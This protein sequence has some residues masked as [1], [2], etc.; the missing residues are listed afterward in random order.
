MNHPFNENRGLSHQKVH[1]ESWVRLCPDAE[2]LERVTSVAMVC[3]K[4]SYPTSREV[5][6]KAATSAPR[7]SL[8]SFADIFTK[9]TC[10]PVM[11]SAY[12]KI[13]SYF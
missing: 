2:P 13:F 6:N 3:L 5:T 10:I 12:E 4:L 7:A 1:R 8:P 9:T 11:V